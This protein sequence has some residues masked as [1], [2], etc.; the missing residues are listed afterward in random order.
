MIN[1]VF[2]LNYVCVVKLYRSGFD[3]VA[4]WHNERA[5]EL[6]QM[7]SVVGT[8]IGFVRSLN[9]LRLQLHH[10]EIWSGSCG[11]MQ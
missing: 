11:S 2:Y 1:V 8:R 7:A 3:D 6:A 5:A 9:W 10:R 4:G